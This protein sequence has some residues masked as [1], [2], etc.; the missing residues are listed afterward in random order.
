MPAGGSRGSRDLLPAVRARTGIRH[1]EGPSGGNG[2]ESSKASKR[3][4]VC[5]T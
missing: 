5:H 4:S 3:P 1:V 2:V